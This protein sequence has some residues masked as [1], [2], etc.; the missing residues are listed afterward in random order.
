MLELL[1]D[2]LFCK[3]LRIC[4]GVGAALIFNDLEKV[5]ASLEPLLHFVN[6]I[7]YRQDMKIYSIINL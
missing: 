1:H 4:I 3:S 6:S 7:I 2:Q 5:H